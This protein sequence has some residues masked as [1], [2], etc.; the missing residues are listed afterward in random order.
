MSL[1]DLPFEIWEL[2]LNQLPLGQRIRCRRVDKKWLFFVDNLLPRSLV[3]SSWRLPCTAK[4]PC[5]NE[6]VKLDNLLVKSNLSF[7]L[8]KV[9]SMKLFSKLERLYLFE[10]EFLTPSMAE[11]CL[12]GLVTLKVLKVNI[13]NQYRVPPYQLSLPSLESLEIRGCCKNSFYDLTLD[14]PNLSKIQ[15]H[16]RLDKLTF[17]YPEK[18][19]C[20]LNVASDENFRPFINLESVTLSHVKNIETSSLLGLRNLKELNF[21]FCKEFKSFDFM[22]RERLLAFAD[23]VK[24][25]SN[26]RQL[27]IVYGGF[28]LNSK[29]KDCKY[30]SGIQTTYEVILENMDM[31]TYLENLDS[32]SNTLPTEA[33]FLEKGSFNNLADQMPKRFLRRFANLSLLYLEGEI[34]NETKLIQLLDDC[35]SLKDLHLMNCSLT[36]HFYQNELRRKCP[37]LRSFGLREASLLNFDF[38]FEFTFLEFVGLDHFDLGFVKAVFKHLKFLKTFKFENQEISHLIAKETRGFY[39]PNLQKDNVFFKSLDDLFAQRS[40][41]EVNPNVQE[42]SA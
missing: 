26:S 20:I 34:E 3:T 18:V 33:L 32:L 38:L 27:R 10:D 5:S 2:I 4:W 29:L 40:T 1:N 19:K 35:R 24:G 22:S 11:K 31:H 30:L 21:S 16:W 39:L 17:L 42:N 23:K 12:N 28:L 41:F 37:F 15:V 13:M 25:I 7:C 36:N 8:E 9:L 6:Q 14:T